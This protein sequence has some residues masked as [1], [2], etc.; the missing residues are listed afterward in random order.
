[1]EDSRDLPIFPR[2][3]AH[4]RVKGREPGFEGENQSEGIPLRTN[5]DARRQ[6]R[7]KI[8]VDI[9]V[10]SQTCGVLKGYTV[11]L[12]ESGISAMLRLEVPT[13]EV[14]ELAFALPYGPVRIHA[15]VRQR[16]AFRYGFQFFES[17]SAHEVICRTCHELAFSSSR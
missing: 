9:R 7:F 1:M 15:V 17:G 14:V 16:N 2:P 13:A 12:S 6:A 4:Q 8:E 3:L 11:D 5:P 10:D